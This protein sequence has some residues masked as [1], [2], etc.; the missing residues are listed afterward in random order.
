M[1]KHD[2]RNHAAKLS[3]YAK[4]PG[5]GEAAREGGREGGLGEPLGIG[6][7]SRTWPRG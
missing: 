5:L 3:K 6:W 1:P 4:L 7:P 2:V